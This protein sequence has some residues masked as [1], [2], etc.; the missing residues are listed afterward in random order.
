MFMRTSASAIAINIIKMSGWSGYSPLLSQGL[1]MCRKQS[2]STAVEAT[3]EPLF[4]CIQ[5]DLRQFLDQGFVPTITPSRPFPEKLNWRII[6]NHSSHKRNQISE[7]GS[8]TSPILFQ[9]CSVFNC[10][11][12]KR[13]VGTPIGAPRRNPNPTRSFLKKFVPQPYIGIMFVQ[14]ISLVQV[15]SRCY[16]AFRLHCLWQP[17]FRGAKDLPYIHMNISSQDSA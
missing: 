9:Q 11:I 17:R 7:H 2:I 13:R 16:H 10:L 5:H 8:L 12:I 4:V 14:I 3:E 6:G 15:D 1:A